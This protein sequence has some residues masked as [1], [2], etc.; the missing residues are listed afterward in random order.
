LNARNTAFTLIEVLVAMTLF[1]VL[2]AIAVPNLQAMRAPYA[3]ESATYEVASHLNMARQRA[4]A[5]NKRHRVVF[6]STGYHIEREASP[7]TFVTVSGTFPVPHEV[8]IGSPN[9][10]NPI[11]NS[12]GMLTGNVTLPIS[13]TGVG[14]KTVTI[15]VLG[16]T[17]IN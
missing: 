15:N 14:T 4:I 5:T 12:R 13:A 3:L 1:G 9:P 7:N 2:Y 11:Y 6:G 10:S 17:T 8:T 16:Q